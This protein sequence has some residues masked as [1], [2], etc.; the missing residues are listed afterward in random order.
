[1]PGTPAVKRVWCPPKESPRHM[2]NTSTT[3]KI[4]LV[5]VLG[6]LACSDKSSDKKDSGGVDAAGG[7]PDSGS[8]DS[9][10]AVG[11]DA[12]ATLLNAPP[13]GAG[14]QLTL[15]STLAA[16][17]ETERC[18]FYRVPS[19]G[20]NVVR[21]EIKYTPGSHH[22][23]LWTTGYTDIPTKDLSGKAVDATTTFDCGSGVFGVWNVTGVVAVHQTEDGAATVDGLPAG[24]AL[25]IPGNA[26][27]LINTHYLN[28]SAKPLDTR[29]AINLHTIPTAQVTQEAGILFLYNP[30]IRV[31]AMGVAKARM[32]CPVN[33][34]ITILNA[35]SHMHRRGVGYVANAVDPASGTVDLLFQGTEW[36]EVMAKKLQPAKNMKA[37]QLIDFACSYKND[38]ARV[39]SQ[40]FTTKDEMCIFF[41]LY[42][43]RDV[44][45]EYCS[46]T[47]DFSGIA[48]GGLWV[49]NG[50]K[51][52]AATAQCMSTSSGTSLYGCVVDSC[53]K[54]SKEA[55]NAGRCLAT[56]GL[57]MCAT[58][59]GGNDEAACKTCVGTKCGPA[60]MALSAAT[61]M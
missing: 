55:S 1:M 51:D 19:E 20:L 31:P 28:A 57:K 37:G 2:K 49:G 25:K 27:L 8:S 16:G 61:C 4:I 38:E 21:E 9:T 10:P 5:G 53:P 26:L 36:A 24:T 6:G 59:C 58:E 3:L 40:G 7:A 34:D 39:V 56:K 43:P 46:L 60:L 45:T 30:F 32:Q 14:V 29:L 41:G 15:T 18:T 42:Y 33:R 13:A 11:G 22:A 35:Q 12:G 17:L 48:F 52:G 50:T 54:I 47:N 23:V 44:K